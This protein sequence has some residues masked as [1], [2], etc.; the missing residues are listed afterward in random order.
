VALYIPTLDVGGA[1]RQLLELAQGL[2]KQR[3]KV[4]ILANS[5]NPI[6]ADE[7][8]SKEGLKVVLLNRNNLLLYPFRLLSTLYREKPCIVSSYLLSA[9]TYTL[10]VRPLLPKIKVVFSVRDS[11]NYS[12]YHGATGIF[13][14]MLIEKSSFL[15]DCY[16]FN[17][18]AG[19]K[20]REGLPDRMVNV[21]PN[22]IDTA[23]YCP[24]QTSRNFLRKETGI[25]AD[26]LVV[27]IVGNFSQYKGY[28][29]FIRA[30]RI[31]A[32]CIPTVHFVAIGNHGTFLGKA[33][34]KLV[35]DQGL[36]SLFY[37]MGLRPDVQRLLPGFDV[38][39]S[40]SVT[41][42][43][44]NAIC[45]GMACGIP[46]VVTD[47]GDS[48]I[49]VGDTGIVVPPSD[50]ESLAAGIVKLLRMTPAERRQLGHKARSRI[51]ENFSIPRMV[52]ATEKVYEQ[53]L[54]SH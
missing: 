2:D 54:G 7:L 11:I 45:E 28:D 26:A 43:F 15:V 46:C 38:L 27:G 20:E 30:T 22:G 19:R 42:G 14:K 48:T 39:C 35:N 10:L 33:M 50:P 24:D 4:L 3:W 51:E 53:L 9:Q 49:I 8:N 17:S 36:D 13:F 16:I 1:E 44:S 25:E 18:V 23:R 32:D 52:A 31:V 5:I 6:I 21:I 34:R 29:T 47:V 37:F 41:E 40:S 12:V